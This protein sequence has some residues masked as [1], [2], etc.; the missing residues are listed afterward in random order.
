[1][2]QKPLF[3]HHGIKYN[4]SVMFSS[5]SQVI[6]YF[7]SFF[8][9]PDSTGL[10][11]GCRLERMELLLSALGNP[12]RSFLSIHLAGSK[13]K[14]S[15][16]AYLSALLT[17]KGEKTGL[18][19]SP[20]L[21]D[22]RERFTL[23]GSFFSDSELIAAAEELKAAVDDFALPE[24]LGVAK[25]TPFELYTA[26]AYLLFKN[27]GCTWA[28]IETGLGGRLD[29][30]NTLFPV[31]EV[32]LPVELEHTAVL[33]NTIEEIAGEKAKI[34]KPN[35]IVFVSWQR[36]EARNVFKSEAESVGVK[37]YYTDEEI[38]S[39]ETETERDGEM[40]RARFSDGE[41]VS[42]AL[43]MRGE[44]QAEN[45][46][47]ALLVAKK[48]G[49]HEGEK[50]LRA[51][52]LVTLPGRF[53]TLR[54]K[55]KTVI[56]DVAH[57]KESVRHTISSFNAIYPDKNRNAVIYASVEGKDTLHMTSLIMKNFSHVII[58]RPGT[59]K[60]SDP[61]AIYD[62]A[63]SLKTEGELELLEN[64]KAA[65]DKGLEKAGDGGALL[66]I[67]SFYLASAILEAIN[68]G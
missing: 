18:Y 33:G 7:D 38:V 54:V 32:L 47:L 61:K 66:V 51:V 59:F 20:H 26:Y 21:A 57:T 23:N 56:L 11:R 60:K 42:L 8:A 27:A 14:G 43:K 68:A 22:Y 41:E 5:F 28:V 44:V 52:E 48:L 46:V 58:S 49:F 1:M 35:S 25:P 30:T 4:F 39:L 31:A 53:Q 19:L 63:L 67:G 10:V 2:E 9:V 37:A 6:N 36:K 55:G 45:A 24:E 12:E 65:L 16:A 13:G 40:V 17:A 29:A 3:N 64:S 15:T 34:I 50:S 62:L